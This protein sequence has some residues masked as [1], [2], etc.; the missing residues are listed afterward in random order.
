LVLD[1]VDAGMK[2]TRI[3]AKHNILRK[4]I[5]D[6]IN[7]YNDTGALVSRSRAGR[8]QALNRA[9]KRA[10]LR[11]VRRNPRCNYAALTTLPHE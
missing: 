10:I 2:K 4:A 9:E 6:T 11:M 1:D 7:R 5:Y 8:P 3:A